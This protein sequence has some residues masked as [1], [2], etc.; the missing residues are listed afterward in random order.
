MNPKKTRQESKKSTIQKIVRTTKMMILRDGYNTITTTKIAKEAD[1][2]VGIIYSYFPEGK[3]AIAKEI[4]KEGIIDLI[5]DKLISSLNEDTF[6]PF[7]KQ[8]LT[9]FVSQHKENKSILIA[10]SIAVL[11]NEE[12]FKDFP[13]LDQMEFDLVKRLFLAMKELGWYKDPVSSITEILLLKIIDI[14]VH[15]HI[16]Y[17][18]I[19]ESDSELIEFLTEFTVKAPIFQ[20]LQ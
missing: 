15:H 4:F 13:F 8:L 20:S 10:M 16:V 2:S 11:T 3:P 12:I 1:I 9:K 6:L 17:E 5:D 7:I 18:K 14:L 19:F